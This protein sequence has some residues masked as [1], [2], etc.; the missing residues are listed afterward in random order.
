LELSGLSGEPVRFAA[1]E[2]QLRAA[3][4]ERS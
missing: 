1:L 3:R 4:P 2:R